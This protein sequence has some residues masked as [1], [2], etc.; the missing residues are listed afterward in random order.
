[1]TINALDYKTEENILNHVTEHSKDHTIIII[2]HRLNTIESC[3]YIY[4]IE[5][6]QIQCVKSK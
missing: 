5:E 2:T 4:K 3:D 6:G 1:M